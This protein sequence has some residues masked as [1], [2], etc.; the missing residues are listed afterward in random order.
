[1]HR[2]R[3][4]CGTTRPIQAMSGWTGGRDG[5]GA[6][7]PLSSDDTAAGRS[8]DRR[9]GAGGRPAA[10]TVR[11]RGNLPASVV[12]GSR[13]V[14][15]PA[16]RAPSPP[17]HQ[18]AGQ[19]RRPSPRLRLS[20]LRLAPAAPRRAARRLHGH[21]GRGARAPDATSVLSASTAGDRGPGSGRSGCPDAA[22][23]GERVRGPA[24][25]RREPIHR[26][27]RTVWI[28]VHPARGLRAVGA[29]AVPDQGRRRPARAWRA[30]MEDVRLVFL[31]RGR[32]A[33]RS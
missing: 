16:P 32:A 10:Q 9:G 13:L 14:S 23:A 33:P 29:P 27:A 26:H 15:E 19:G 25:H 8:R 18:A 4:Q 21:L 20:A 12:A 5:C 22:R 24:G 17:G 11:R 3:R 31:W 30:Q 6:E 1:M 28:G 2:P 7:G